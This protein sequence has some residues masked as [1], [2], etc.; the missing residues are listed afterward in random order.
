M[1][2]LTA[3][4]WCPNAIPTHRG[5]VKPNP[6]GKGGNPELIHSMKISQSDIDEFFGGSVTEEV[7]LTEAGVGNK[8][9]EDMNDVERDAVTETNKGM[10]GS[11]LK[12]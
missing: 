4:T 10:F 5:W 12:G 6:P 11:F 7:V 8:S 2:K 9:L 1:A 3:P